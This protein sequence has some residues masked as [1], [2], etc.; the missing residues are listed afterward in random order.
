MDADDMTE[1]ASSGSGKK[2][3][4]TREISLNWCIEGATD[5]QQAKKIQNEV[6]FMMLK[7]FANEVTALDQTNQELQWDSNQKEK[8][9]Q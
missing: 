7:T 3:Q 5:R 4:E 2:R 9:F 8:E 1:V 6:L